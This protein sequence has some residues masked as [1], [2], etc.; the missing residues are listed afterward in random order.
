MIF[1]WGGTLTPWHTIEPR[2]AWITAVDDHELADRLMAAEHELWLR[3]R[4][5]HRSGSMDDVFAAAGV[6]PTEQMLAAIS[7]WWEPHTL[8]DPDVPPLF[9]ALRDRSI[10]IG[11]LSNTLWSRA[12][13]ERIFARDGVLDSIDGA[14][15][16][17]EIPWTKPHREAFRAALE[18]V[19]VADPAEAVFVGD[20]PFDDVHGAKSAGMRAVLLPHSDIP[21]VQKGPVE[22]EPDA[23]IQRLGDLLAVI[24]AWR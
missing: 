11:V 13:H 12:E 3:S 23:V 1:D 20:R 9:D 21:E 19:S 15:Y 10:K 5:E 24:D 16:S 17:S 18:A 22:G 4:D 2:E 8:L 14:V 6:E 7:E